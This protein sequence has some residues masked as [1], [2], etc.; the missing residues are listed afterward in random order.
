MNFHKFFQ[1][2]Y[3]IFAI[4]FFA[5]AFTKFQNND[6]SWWISGL[7]GLGAVFMFFLKRRFAK[8]YNKK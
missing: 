3:L 2:I 7:L 5:D 1:Y 4:L 8:T 6:T